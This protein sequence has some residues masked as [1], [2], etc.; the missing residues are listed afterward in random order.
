MSPLRIGQL[1]EKRGLTAYQL[2]KAS[3]GRISKS[4]AYRLANGEVERLSSETVA[5]LCEILK[6]KPGDLF[7]DA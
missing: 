1:L 7:A 4:T 2:S 5:A 6:C 3:D